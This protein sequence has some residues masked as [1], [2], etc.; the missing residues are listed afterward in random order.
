AVFRR[1][2]ALALKSRFDSLGVSENCLL[3]PLSEN[4]MIEM[5]FRRLFMLV[6][7]A[8]VST[9]DQNPALQLDALKTAMCERVFVEKASGA[10]R[11][12]PELKA[13]LEYLR[14]GDTLVIWKLDR[15]ARTLKQLVETVE[16]LAAR[17]IGL[18]SLTEAIDTT[19]AGGRLIF[20]VFCALAEF[21]RSNIRE[22]TRAGLEAARARGRQGGRPA[23]LDGKALAAAKA[24]LADPDITV[25]DAAKHL[26]VAPSTLYKYFPGGKGSLHL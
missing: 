15:L 22:R 17:D 20:H 12:R 1:R 2:Q 6:G 9:Q 5:S 21:E 16:G 8:R 25:E 4:V 23:A 13:A 26:H 18:C 14:A 24:L 19:T 11:E 3:K 10:L 7:Y